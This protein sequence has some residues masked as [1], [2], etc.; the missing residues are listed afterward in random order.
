[1]GQLMIKGHSILQN[2]ICKIMT[3]LTIML[4]IFFIDYTTADAYNLQQYTVATDT[5]KIYGDGKTKDAKNLTLFCFGAER[6]YGY[7]DDSS[8][9]FEGFFGVRLKVSGKKVS[10]TPYDHTVSGTYSKS[11]IVISKMTDYTHENEVARFDDVSKDTS[12]IYTVTDTGIFSVSDFAYED[13]KHIVKAYFYNDGNNLYTCRVTNQ[14]YDKFNEIIKH[15]NNLIGDA[16]PKKYLSNEGITYPTSGDYGRCVHTDEFEKIAEELLSEYDRKTKWS[17][18]AKVFLFVNYL[19][20]NY[21]YDNY[22]VHDLDMV[23]RA[24][25]AGIFTDDN[26]YMYGNHV[27]VCWDYA[28]VLT[29]MIRYAGIPCTSVECDDHTAIAVYL[30]GEWC[31]IDPTPLMNYSCDT[32][33][34]SKDKWK[35]DVHVYKYSEEYGTYDYFMD[36]DSHDKEIWNAENIERYRKL[37]ENSQN[38]SMQ[39]HDL[40]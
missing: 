13:S 22:R 29:I 21:A 20:Q 25:V 27:G 19:T 6:T 34:T 11:A 12:V 33:D 5:V 7:I 30:Y 36:F 18:D 38:R 31:M 9:D 14:P 28:N 3:L 1:M 17:D 4:A 35:K 15:W 8:V 10:I 2:K 32:K 40:H 16:N 23:S 39:F 37:T 24:N 26:Y